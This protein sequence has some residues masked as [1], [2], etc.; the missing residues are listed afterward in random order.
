MNNKC[1]AKFATSE[2]AMYDD[3]TNTILYG[4]SDRMQALGVNDG[5]CN[6]LINPMIYTNRQKCSGGTASGNPYRETFGMLDNNM[7]YV[8]I[9]II[10]ILLI[11]WKMPETKLPSSP[12]VKV[13]PNR[14]ESHRKY[15]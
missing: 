3:K 6:D 8:Y 15:N 4:I 11:I 7:D 2:G 9:I 14:I 12:R 1:A 10:I 5:S 13:P